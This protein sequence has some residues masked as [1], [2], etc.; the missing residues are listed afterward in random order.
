M[1]CTIKRGHPA[2]ISMKE[3]CGNGYWRFR[4]GIGRSLRDELLNRYITNGWTL[5]EKQYLYG[6]VFDSVLFHLLNTV[7]APTHHIPW[8]QDSIDNDEQ[9]KYYKPHILAQNHG[10]WPQFDKFDNF[11]NFDQFNRTFNEFNDTKS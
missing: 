7:L 11:D 3:Y 6:Q 4:I 1:W 10:Y 5:Q 9:L 8:T 2:L